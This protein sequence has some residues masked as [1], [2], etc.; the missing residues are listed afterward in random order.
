MLKKGLIFGEFIIAAALAMTLTGGGK[1]AEA[2][3]NRDTTGQAI[4]QEYH[5]AA[6][7]DN[8]GHNLD[9]E[10]EPELVIHSDFVCEK[11]DPKLIQAAVEGFE[12]YFD[13][14]VDPS[15]FDVNV[16]AFEPFEDL[17]GSYSVDF[18]VPE[19]YE[20][21]RADGSIGPDG[22][23][24]PEI[25]EKMR[26]QFYATFTKD[27][28]IDGLY[29][30]YMGWEVSEVPLNVEES[31]RAAEEFLKSHEMI[32]DGKLDFMGATIIADSRT[33]LTYG[34]GKDGAVQVAVDTYAGKVEHFEY[35]SRK[36]AEIII[37]PMEEGSGLG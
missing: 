32:A 6:A 22:F 2:A 26:P 11:D 15:Q 1:P 29:L 4:Q 5:A 16:Y 17:E 8:A 12:K 36:Q 9:A 21:L 35:M 24:L 28:E 19:N 25:K 14:T 33:V 10:A 37:K 31:K 27:K 3:A 30:S 7:D 13:V 34:N 23:P 20:L 18:S